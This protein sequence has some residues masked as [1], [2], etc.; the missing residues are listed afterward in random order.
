MLSLDGADLLS[1][2]TQTSDR[3]S[4]YSS[5]R[6]SPELS[7]NPYQDSYGSE[8]LESPMDAP[9][10][11][12]SFGSGDTEMMLPPTVSTYN[13]RQKELP[14]PPDLE[15]LRRDLRDCLGDNQKVLDEIKDSEEV[16]KGTPAGPSIHVRNPSTMTIT[17]TNSQLNGDSPALPLSPGQGSNQ[18]QGWHE[19]QGMHLLDITT[20]AIRAA[21]MYYTAHEQ[22]A[23][24][25]A[26]KSERKIRQELMSVLD[27]LKRM[28]SRN[29][30]G[31][32]RKEERISIEEWVISVEDLLREEEKREKEELEERA[33]REW[34]DGEWTGRE[35]QREWL[36]LKSFDT[37]PLELPKW[38]T[39]DESA[40]LPTPFLKALQTGLRLVKL[41]NEILKKSRRR[42]GTITTFYTDTLKPYRAA[43]N[44][45]YWVKASEI[46]WEIKLPE[47]DIMGV[48][49][50]K[51][52]KAWKGFEEAVKVWTK[53]VREQIV[54]DWKEDE[55]KKRR[56]SSHVERDG[57]RRVSAIYESGS[58][59][60]RVSQAIS[61]AP[62]NIDTSVSDLDISSN[63]LD[64]SASTLDN[65]VVDTSLKIDTSAKPGELRATI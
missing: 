14:P 8:I 30:A 47:V 52:Q 43:E 31:G 17:P 33:N 13:Y 12:G 28:A 48:V 63:T 2:T 34:M 11:F 57:S 46:R 40:E 41:H 24:L 4:T 10:G 65:S 25:S 55:D 22:P 18:D 42:D 15:T 20:L 5:M 27:V 51:D 39:H 45:R 6:S 53:G 21:R 50:G 58:A 35:E 32:I 9:E 37:D 26:I 7:T 61:E 60:R 44:L 16:E 19:L 38:E 36:F 64:T 62:S 23:R 56:S 29:W 59:S 54:R 49:Y 1:P 3:D